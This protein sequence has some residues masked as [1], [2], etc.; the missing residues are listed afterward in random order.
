[1][2]HSSSTM[3]YGALDNDDF[4]MYV[5]GLAAAVRNIDGESPELV[6]AN[7]RESWQP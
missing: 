2:V 1:M 4:F 7:T 6:V 3:L 5:G